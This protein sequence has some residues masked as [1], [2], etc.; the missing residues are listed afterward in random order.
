VTDGLW[1]EISVVTTPR[2]VSGIWLGEGSPWGRTAAN[3]PLA[4]RALS[5][6]REYLAG[7]R[8]T[9]DLPLDLSAAT[10]FRGAVLEALLAVPFGAV[11]SYA[12]LAERVGSRS[13]RA[14]G[15]A[16]G[17]NPLPIVVPCH[18]VITRNGRLGGYSG[19]IDRKVALLALEGIR[20]HGSAFSSPIARAG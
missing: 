9:F 16:V 11:V 13:P 5:Q 10:S 6:L 17:W 2:G 18:R 7:A 8:T 4:V 20:A 1:R 3:D 15:Q 12:G 14:V 19:G